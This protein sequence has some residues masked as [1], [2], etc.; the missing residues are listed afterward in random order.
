[1]QPCRQFKQTKELPEQLPLERFFEEQ[2][3]AV[4]PFTNCP[5]DLIVYICSFL[6][7]KS[8]LAFKL[9]NKMTNEVWFG[10]VWLFIC[11]L[12]CVRAVSV[13]IQHILVDWPFRIPVETV[14]STRLWCVCQRTIRTW[15]AATGSQLATVLLATEPGWCCCCYQI[16]S[17]Y[18]VVNHTQGENSRF[19][20]RD[21]K[22][23]QSNGCGGTVAR[24]WRD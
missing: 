22:F 6:P 7:F 5:L 13:L 14:V 20:R 10:L 11:L 18:C 1:M 17:C 12:V 15:T 23:E 19:E 9:T 4:H 8:I 3:M 21:V 24:T 2:A 16:S